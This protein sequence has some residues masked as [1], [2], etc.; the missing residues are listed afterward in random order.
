LFFDSETIIKAKDGHL[1][2]QK[3]KT[4]PHHAVFV[5]KGLRIC[6]QI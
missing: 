1:N 2:L 4:K 5:A 3:K 6:R